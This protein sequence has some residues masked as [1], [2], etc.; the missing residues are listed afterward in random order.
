MGLDQYAMARTPEGEAEEIAYWRKH[1]NLQGWMENLWI[2]KGAQGGT[3]FNCVELE[4]T[5]EDIDR[6]EQDIRDELLPSTQG[7][8]FGD[9]AD[10][11]YHDEDL[12]FCLNARKILEDEGELFYTSW[13]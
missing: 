13:W 8:F 1:P 4:L 3:E 11:V 6:L 12:E 7:F 10:K 9:E 2:E 5:L